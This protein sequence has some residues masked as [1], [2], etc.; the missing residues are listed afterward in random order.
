MR[1]R[2][3]LSHIAL[4]SPKGQREPQ[5]QA[6]FLKTL[7]QSP[8]PQA[9]ARVPGPTVS[10]GASLNATTGIHRGHYGYS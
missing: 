8:L 5:T 6:G 1:V 4:Y 7:A 10:C 3:I 2:T 9:T